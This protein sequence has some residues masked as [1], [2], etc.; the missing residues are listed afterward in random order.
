MGRL[1]KHLNTTVRNVKRVLKPVL[2]YIHRSSLGLGLGLGILGTIGAYEAVNTLADHYPNKFHKY[3]GTE[4]VVCKQKVPNTITVGIEVSLEEMIRQTIF[5]T[6]D[7]GN[8][9]SAGFMY[10][11]P[12]ETGSYANGERVF[13][14]QRTHSAVCTAINSSTSKIPVIVGD[15]GEGGYTTRVELGLPS[16][17]VLGSYY[18][19]KKSPELTSFPSLLTSDGE[20]PK[21]RI[22]IEKIKD[23]Y[24]N[25]AATLRDLEVGYV[26]GPVLDTVRNIEDSKEVNIIAGNDRSFSSN[27][28]TVIDLARLYIEAMHDQGIKVIGKHYF[29]VGYTSVDPHVSIP[30]T[31]TMT[32]NERADA[33]AP[34]IALAS[35][36]D[37]IMVTHIHHQDRN[38]PDTFSPAVYRYLRDE[39][40]FK[41]IIIAD[42]LYMGAVEERYGERGDTW[43][44]DAVIDTLAAGADGV[45]LKY[46]QEIPDITVA[47]AQKMRTERA[48]QEQMEQ[49]FQRLMQFKGIKVESNSGVDYV[50]PEIDTP[51]I[52]W[53]RKKIDEGDTLLGLIARENATIVGLDASGYPTVLDTM[54]YDQIERQFILLNHIT[55]RQMRARKEYYLP[56]FK[57]EGVV[58]EEQGG[59][60][61]HPEA[62]PVSA[63][64]LFTVKVRTGL[65]FYNYLA[66][67]GETVIG[68]DGNF[69]PLRAGPLSPHY[70][71]F[72]RN[73][74]NV[75]SVNKLQADMPYVFL[76][77]NGNGTIEFKDPYHD[78]K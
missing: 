41:G 28:K 65:S 22:R 64:N 13:T 30:S 29:G 44:I 1:R 51:E 20:L 24:R 40:R 26:F 35:D 3:F 53:V 69:L 15:E 76:D 55:P 72:K 18:E 45:I 50:L 33:A 16:A 70:Y 48:F 71:A 7:D 8:P 14:P 36:L 61:Q 5:T 19:G 73:N 59:M 23:L 4:N 10:L 60:Q 6:R 66:G 57:G 78:L 67:E 21:K 58:Y 52:K 62:K 75:I 2:S 54:R 17:E 56:N 37:G 38:V 27:P 32:K 74:P 25:A 49:S 31:E 77:L 47:V 68:D 42:D 9:F 12:N 11:T 39:L 46:P 43:I 63:Q 34:F